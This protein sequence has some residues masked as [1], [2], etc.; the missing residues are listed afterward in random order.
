[1]RGRA[2]L[3][4]CGVF[5]GSAGASAQFPQTPVTPP[6]SISPGL[7]A[8]PGAPRALPPGVMPPQPFTAPPSAVPQ[9]AYVPNPPTQPGLPEGANPL[10]P[11]DVP[12]P[13]PEEKQPLDGSRVTM[14]RD[15]G[16]WQVWNGAKLFRDLGA[17]ENDAKD[18]VRSLH[19]M[20]ATEWVTIGG[21]ARPVVEYG[22]V[23]GLP[24]VVAGFPKN[25]LHIDLQKVR[26]EA[27]KGVWCLRDDDHIHFNFGLRRQDADQTLAV[28]RKY[29][30]NRVGQIG[31]P[32]VVMSYLF[33]A[34]GGDAVGKPTLG[35]L[36]AALQEANMAQT[37]I[38]VP[39]LGYVGEMVK[40][41][42]RKVEVRREK[43]DWVVACGAD[44]F[45]RF[46]PNEWLARDAARIIQDCRFTE[47]CRASGSGGLTFFLINGKAPT[48]VPFAM[49]G[50]RFSPNELR[51]AQAGDRFMVAM[52]GKPLFDVG[53]AADGE[54][55]IKLLKHFGFD[56]VC[57]LGTGKA[58]LMFLAKNR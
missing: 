27:V 38:L 57:Q 44:V 23:N 14:K 58:S 42:S 15:A 5:L 24:S 18:L 50:P 1:M 9:G 46:G 17:S 45:A 21:A 4:G 20:H 34:V 29:G 7:P 13:F 3:A 10:T 35:G 33:V 41:D 22:L 16:S 48:R 31:Y 49:Q 6:G 25:V 37:G 52:Q 11:R 47:F 54:A 53:G 2:V 26:V 55:L 39:G 28:I 30:F 51:V 40:I 8:S 32:S 19:A 56:Q 12:L 36:N 43:A